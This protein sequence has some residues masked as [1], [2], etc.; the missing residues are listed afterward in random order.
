MCAHLPTI[1]SGRIWVCC[2]F[3]CGWRLFFHFHIWLHPV[4]QGMKKTRLTR[5]Y[6]RSDFASGCR[7]HLGLSPCRQ[8]A[9]AKLLCNTLQGFHRIGPSFVG[10]S[11]V[12]FTSFPLLARLGAL[13]LGLV[14]ITF[15]CRGKRAVH[16][17]GWTTSQAQVLQAADKP[18]LLWILARATETVK[19]SSWNNHSWV[20]G[21]TSSQL[22]QIFCIDR[23][24]SIYSTDSW[25]IR[26][27]LLRV[28]W[29]NISE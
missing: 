22:M 3:S 21:N 4:C 2:Q 8:A 17:K 16:L 12:T 1:S 5:Y 10:S 13:A 25:F 29:V 14:T 28:C 24:N 23:S 19:H 6:T 11:L 9:K 20:R 18:L 15:G 26:I 27:L 7:A